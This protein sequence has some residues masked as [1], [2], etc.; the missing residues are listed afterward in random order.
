M[1]KIGEF[2]I[3]LVIKWI[4][5]ANKIASI[6]NDDLL[7][8]IFNLFLE[9]LID[10]CWRGAC[11]DTSAAFY[12]ALSEYGFSPKLCIGVVSAPSGENFDHSW[13]EL[14]NLIYDFSIFYPMNCGAVLSGPIFALID[15]NIMKNTNLLFGDKSKKLSS[16]AD[17]IAKISLEDYQ[18]I[19]PNNHLCLWEMAS[20]IGSRIPRDNPNW[21]TLDPLAIE[22]KYGKKTRIIF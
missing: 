9:V 6:K 4:K 18:K 10:K 13:V 22:K 8:D 19:R 17:K 15:I 21:K 20:Q 3:N 7:A 2:D 14:D 16:P 12:M 1:K 5:N 11:H